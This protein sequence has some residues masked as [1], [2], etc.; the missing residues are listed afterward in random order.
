V[1]MQPNKALQQT[2]RGVEAILRGLAIID[3]RFAAERQC[4]ADL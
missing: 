4:W 1:G 2:K 3:V